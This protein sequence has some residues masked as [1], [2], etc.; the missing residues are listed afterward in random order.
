MFPCGCFSRSISMTKIA[1]KRESPSSRRGLRDWGHRSQP[2]PATETSTAGAAAFSRRELI[3]GLTQ[4]E[5][6]FLQQPLGTRRLQIEANEARTIQAAGLKKA[7]K[8][9]RTAHEELRSSEQ[10]KDEALKAALVEKDAALRQLKRQIA[11]AT[12]GAK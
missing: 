9:V 4:L 6:S 12:R 5:L 11:F 1:S 3:H 7:V 8:A 10:A 2:A